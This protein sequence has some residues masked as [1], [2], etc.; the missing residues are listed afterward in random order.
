MPKQATVIVLSEQEQEGLLQITRR[1]RS[2]Q[3]VA[4]RARIVLASAQRHTNVQIADELG[5]CVDT[6]RLWRDR[7]AGLQGIDLETL[8]LAERL[9]DAPRPGANPQFTTEQRCQMAVLACE[10]PAKAGRPIK[11]SDGARNC[12]RTEGTGHCRAN[13]APTCSALAQKRGLQPHR[14]RYWLTEVPD[15]QR[16]EKIR[17][18]CEMYAKAPVR[19]KQGERTI[20][21]DELTGVQALERKYPDLPM[22]PGHVLRREFEY[23]RHGTLSCFFNFDVVSGQVIEPSFGPTRTEEDALAHIQRLIASDSTVTKWHLI[24]DNL[25]IHQS[26]SL[27][28]W[29]AEQEEI[30]Q[31]TLGVKGKCGILRSMKSRAAFLHD[32]AHRV[33]FYYTPK[34]ASWMN[35][36][37]IWLSILM[38]KLLK[39]GNFTSQDNLHDQ[40]LAFIAYYNRT[41]AKPIKWTYTGL[42]PDR[43]AI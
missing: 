32:P 3:Q 19:A 25:N 26:E 24:L 4:M 18:G 9:Q 12:R 16:D 30:D 7:W 6:V 8:S 40:I 37:E 17:E 15:D 11:K 10:A 34:H 41:M 38:R 2:E 36:V 42:S 13:L 43:G 14:F 20:S 22:Q 29:V 33:V 21:L 5:I 27:V 39:R 23:V 31:D 1:H 35:Q 28:L